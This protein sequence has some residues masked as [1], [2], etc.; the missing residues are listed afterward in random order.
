[1]QIPWQMFS[2]HVAAKAYFP[3]SLFAPARH[4]QRGNGKQ[5]EGDRDE[6]IFVFVR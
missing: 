4:T 6:N 1:M 3:I 5:E 2:G